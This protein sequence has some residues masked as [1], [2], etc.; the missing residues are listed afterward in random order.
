[1]YKNIVIPLE[2]TQ[3]DGAILSHIRPLA[4]LTGA[5][6]WLV[7][8]ADGHVARNQAQLNLADS[9]EMQSD[10]EYLEKRR[11]ELAGEG[12]AVEVVLKCGDPTKEIL[13]LAERVPADLIAMST[14]GHGI[15]MDV[16]LGSVASGVRHK[17]DIPVLLLRSKRA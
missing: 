1:M 10:R 15:L 16:L 4:K 2:N 14:H 11:G 7:H 8:V 12:F 5:K 3:A 6:L 9:E 13:A 17:T